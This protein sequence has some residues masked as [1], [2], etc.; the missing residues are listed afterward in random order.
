MMNIGMRPTFGGNQRTLEAYLLNFEGNIYDKELLVRFIHRIRE[1]QRFDNTEQ[2]AAQLKRD[3]AEI[4]K[5][6]IQNQ[7]NE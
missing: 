5:L 4:K 7:A 3:E 6:F 1:E 2:L